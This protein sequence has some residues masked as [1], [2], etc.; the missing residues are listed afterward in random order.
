HLPVQ[1]GDDD[2]LSHMRRGYTVQQ[3]RDIVSELREKM[4]DLAISTDII[5]GYPDETEEQYQRTLDLVSEIEFDF[6]FMF[7]YSEREGTLASKKIPDTIPADVKQRRLAA[8]IAM[9]EK[10][11]LTR[12]QRRVDQT[13]EVLVTGEARKKDG[14]W[15]GKSEDFKTV[16]FTPPE[17]IA[18]GQLLKVKISHCT[19][20]TLFGNVMGSAR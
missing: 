17:D 16:V 15:I 1:S 8:L 7:A 10:I 4:P 3:F 5:V 20:H 6:A 11:G 12:Y 13:V 19:A 14:N 2:I 9:Q 18:V